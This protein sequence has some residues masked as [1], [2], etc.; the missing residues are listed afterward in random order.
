MVKEYLVY[1]MQKVTITVV[2]VILPQLGTF[3]RGKKKRLIHVLQDCFQVLQ[4]I[5][6][7]ASI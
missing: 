4:N 2:T 6:T 3:L 5:T 7:Q 1:V